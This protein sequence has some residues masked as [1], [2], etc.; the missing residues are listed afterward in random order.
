MWMPLRNAPQT[1]K[2]GISLSTSTGLF[3]F[4]FHTCVA[5]H[6]PRTQGNG[7]YTSCCFLPGT[8]QA[9]TVTSIGE[10]GDKATILSSLA[11]QRRGGMRFQAKLSKRI[12]RFLVAVLPCLQLLPSTLRSC[13]GPSDTATESRSFYILLFLVASLTCKIVVWDEVQTT[14]KGANGASNVGEP[15]G[16]IESA[17]LLLHRPKR[18]AV[19]VRARGFQRTSE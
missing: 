15:D 5:F 2:S 10:V 11:G 4:L 17:Q 9:I 18:Q 3:R 8:T 13:Y 12:L 14:T 7:V 16:T 6:R 19:K 1:Q